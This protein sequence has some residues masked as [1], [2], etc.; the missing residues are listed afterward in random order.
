MLYNLHYCSVACC[1]LVHQHRRHQT[2]HSQLEVWIGMLSLNIETSSCCHEILR[3]PSLINIIWVCAR[4]VCHCSENWAHLFITIELKKD[5][6][7]GS[8][9]TLQ[10]C[11]WFQLEKISSRLKV[12]MCNPT[13]CCYFE[14]S[15]RVSFCVVVVSEFAIDI[16]RHI[17]ILIYHESQ[18]SNNQGNKNCNANKENNGGKIPC[19]KVHCHHF[20]ESVIVLPHVAVAPHPYSSERM[21]LWLCSHCSVRSKRN[22][23]CE[24]ECNMIGVWVYVWV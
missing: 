11:A 3:F 15:G 21:G 14:F 10:V 7:F 23:E 6:R 24:C 8:V 16:T 2:V 22:C 17:Y 13:F 18:M 1:L 9:V 4:R 20:Q 12:R 19:S 5:I